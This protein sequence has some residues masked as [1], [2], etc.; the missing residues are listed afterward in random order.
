MLYQFFV[1]LELSA[2]VVDSAVEL[3]LRKVI[4]DL[5]DEVSQL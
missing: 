4:D 1:R 3:D 2:A 5:V